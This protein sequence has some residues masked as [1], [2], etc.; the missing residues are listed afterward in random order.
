MAQTL[1]TTPLANEQE[2]RREALTSLLG[3]NGMALRDDSQLACR[4]I[5][6]GGDL[7]LTAHELLCTHFLFVH[8]KYDANCQHHLRELAKMVHETYNL[9]WKLSW[10]LA[11]EYG[12]PAM[13]LF[14]LAETGYFMPEFD[15]RPAATP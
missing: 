1:G 9:P 3:R 8:T 15:L 11:R 5:L 10:A 4:F 14:S 12:V 2:A 6:H 13:K 7:Q